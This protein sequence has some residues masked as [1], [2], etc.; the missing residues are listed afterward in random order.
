VELAGLVI[1]T[2]VLVPGGID[3]PIALPMPKVGAAGMGGDPDPGTAEPVIGLANVGVIDHVAVVQEGLVAVLH[4]RT[5][6]D[7]HGGIPNRGH[8]ARGGQRHQRE[9]GQGRQRL[10]VHGVVSSRGG[11]GFRV[12][13]GRMRYP[14]HRILW[15]AA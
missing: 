2:A 7:T 13:L 1:G 6:G 15:I 12:G 11:S 8:A 4:W 3:V 9:E 10:A 14:R 5:I